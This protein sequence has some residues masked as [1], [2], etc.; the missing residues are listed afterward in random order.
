MST[1]HSRWLVATMG[2]CVVGLALTMGACGSGQGDAGAG[3]TSR[4]TFD[5]E[6]VRFA[7]G[8]VPRQRQASYMGMLAEGR[9]SNTM[10][11]RM[12]R[13]IETSQDGWTDAMS[14]CLAGWGRSAPQ[15]M[16]GG[17]LDGGPMMG[18]DA[19]AMMTSDDLA[20]L[21]ASSGAGFDQMFLTMMA[22]HHR[23]TLA[24]A[25]EEARKGLDPAALKMARKV[26]IVEQRQ[27]LAIRRLRGTASRP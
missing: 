22:R 15:G 16:M 23:A 8:M 5:H 11:L 9:T 19:F 6:D 17:A 24:L 2:G 10:V 7:Q 25:D 1:S 12:A 27:L 14:T 20:R 4:H 26:G 13:R 18:G 3:T 21:A